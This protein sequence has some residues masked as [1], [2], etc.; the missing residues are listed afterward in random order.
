MCAHIWQVPQLSPSL[1][2]YQQISMHGFNLP[3]WVADNGGEA[4]LGMLE[5]ISELVQ[6][7]SPTHVTD[8]RRPTH[9]GRRT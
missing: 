5:S 7:T 4:Y 1:I 9:V 2:M 3:Q 6:A 8:A